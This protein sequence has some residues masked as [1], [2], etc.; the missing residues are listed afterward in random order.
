MELSL[1]VISMGNTHL[2]SFIFNNKFF[3]S[4]N[5]FFIASIGKFKEILNENESNFIGT[6]RKFCEA[7][8]KLEKHKI[9]KNLSSQKIIQNFNASVSPCKGEI[10]KSIV[11]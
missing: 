7:L 8:E 2:I 4:S 5:F 11:C 3:S 6:D 9:Y 10:W 1:H